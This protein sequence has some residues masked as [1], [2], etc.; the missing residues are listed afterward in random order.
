MRPH[1]FPEEFDNMRS[2]GFFCNKKNRMEQK[3]SHSS[4]EAR[5]VE[6]ANHIWQPQDEAPSTWYALS[7]KSRLKP[8]NAL[9]NAS[10][11][12]YMIW[13]VK[14]WTPGRLNEPFFALKLFMSIAVRVVENILLLL[15]GTACPVKCNTSLDTFA[16]FWHRIC[17][18]TTTITASFPHVWDW[19]SDCSV[20]I[21]VILFWMKSRM[22]IQSDSWDEFFW[23][24]LP[25]HIHQWSTHNNSIESVYMTWL[26]RP[27]VT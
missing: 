15:P 11:I 19:L 17:P 20:F 25:T 3:T 10:T 22:Q 7:G 13:D 5:G 16:T 18:D 2:L 8:A 9:K 6:W 23:S 27:A 14:H 1:S 21:F 26:L 24:Q 4:C 12:V